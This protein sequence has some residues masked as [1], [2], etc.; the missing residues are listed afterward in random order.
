MKIMVF[1]GLIGMM[2]P[3]V[4]HGQ[5]MMAQEVASQKVYV[6][7][8]QLFIADREMFA[9]VA[10]EWIP[11][12][13]IHADANGIYIKP[14]IDYSFIRWMCPTCGYNNDGQAQTCQRDLRTGGKCGYP[15]PRS[16]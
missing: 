11:V 9:C 5:S 2:L 6:D 12:N 3:M 14:C 16:K 7:S 15:R 10:G 4:S 1:L 8:S 13:A